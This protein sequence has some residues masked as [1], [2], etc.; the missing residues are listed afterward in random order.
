[1]YCSNRTKS[2]YEKLGY[3]EANDTCVMSFEAWGNSLQLLIS[4][5][6]SASAQ[7]ITM[8]KIDIISVI[9]LYIS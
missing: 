8:N 4:I 2:F 3:K 5:N 7:F 6:T 9:I 1:L